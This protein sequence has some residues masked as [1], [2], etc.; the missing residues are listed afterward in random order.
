MANVS[1]VICRLAAKKMGTA[2]SPE[3]IIE[4][5]TTLLYVQLVIKINGQLHHLQT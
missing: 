1:N 3:L 2:P 4:Y 5:R